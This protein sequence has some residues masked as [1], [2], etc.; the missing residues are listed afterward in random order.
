MEVHGIDA[1][2]A[3]AMLADYV[4][5]GMGTQELLAELQ[6]AV[7]PRTLV[8]KSPAYALNLDTLNR[9]E[10]LFEN[11]RYIH[12][13][14]HPQ[15]MIASFEKNHLAQTLHLHDHDFADHTLGEMVWTVSHQNILT[16]LKRIPENRQS[17]VLFE[18]LVQ[19]PD[20]TIKQICKDLSLSYY[21]EMVHPYENTV[22]K[23][24]DGI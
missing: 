1:D 12:L 22:R 2:G 3:K 11:A 4:A 20:S 16:F 9:A 15:S 6:S 8:D 18:S 13:V 19:Q 7:Y 5:Q 21:P 24:T 17:R 10:S 23:M 14:R